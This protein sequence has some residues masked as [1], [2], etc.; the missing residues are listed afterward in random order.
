MERWNGIVEWWNGGIV[1]LATM[2][3]DPVPH[4]L[5]ARAYYAAQL[6]QGERIGQRCRLRERRRGK[7]HRAHA[8]SLAIDLDSILLYCYF[9]H[10]QNAQVAWCLFNLLLSLLPCHNIMDLNAISLALPGTKA[11]V[12]L[13]VTVPLTFI[14]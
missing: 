9:Q 7:S 4:H 6:E 14:E 10:R 2:T 5:F 13:L 12:V 3:N 8:D 11:W 1:E